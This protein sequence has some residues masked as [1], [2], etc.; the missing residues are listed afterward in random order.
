MKEVFGGITLI[1]SFFILFWV[2]AFSLDPDKISLMAQV[3]WL[4]VAGVTVLGYLS[5]RVYDKLVPQGGQTIQQH[6]QIIINSIYK[7]N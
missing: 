4:Y 1:C 3:P 5:S 6:N 7:E 2:F